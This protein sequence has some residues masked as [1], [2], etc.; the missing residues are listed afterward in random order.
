MSKLLVVVDMQ[1]DFITGSLG[2]KE[3]EAI[4]E[5]VKDKIKAYRE[6]GSEVVYTRDTHGANY[7]ETKEGSNLPVVHCIQGTWGWELESHIE[8]T[9]TLE[10]K[11]FDKKN[12]W[13]YAIRRIYSS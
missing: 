2:T 8:E 10:D 5:K 6:N 1:N 11:V 3:A 9:R 7:L 13:Q 12:V 4:V